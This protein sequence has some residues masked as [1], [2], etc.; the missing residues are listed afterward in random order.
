MNECVNVWNVSILCL[1][2][3]EDPASSGARFASNKDN[4]SLIIL[5]ESGQICL[6][7]NWCRKQIRDAR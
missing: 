1:G 6:P 2:L 3:K 7:F 5:G 4:I